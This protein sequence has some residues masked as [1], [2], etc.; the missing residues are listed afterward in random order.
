MNIEPDMLRPGLH[1]PN[2]SILLQSDSIIEEIE[3]EDDELN[4]E[5]NFYVSWESHKRKLLTK[6]EQAKLMDEDARSTGIFQ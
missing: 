4:S 3:I 2:K 6:D 5:N 1:K